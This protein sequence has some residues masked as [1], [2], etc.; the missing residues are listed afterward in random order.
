M[1]LS[2]VI[3][4]NCYNIDG[5]VIVGI[6]SSLKP[7]ILIVEDETIVA[8]D[9][10]YLI[11]EMG[12]IVVG[13][14]TNA[15]QAIDLASTSDPH[16]ILMDIRLDG[17]GDGIKAVETI[18]ATSEARIVYLTA[19]ADNNTIKRIETTKPFAYILCQP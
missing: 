6:T 5:E 12:C 8:L 18:Q 3:I 19:Y 17:D 15:R 1:C 2:A 16:I 11:K 13:V 14:A 9:L 10:S 4:G 7:R